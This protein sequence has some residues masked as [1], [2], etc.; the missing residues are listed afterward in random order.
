[1]IP[2][3]LIILIDLGALATAN[4]CMMKQLICPIFVLLS[5]PMFVHSQT[6]M[7]GL[8][9]KPSF[10]YLRSSERANL[11]CNNSENWRCQ[12][13]VPNTYAVNMNYW[14]R[15]ESNSSPFYFQ[16]ELGLMYL[17][18]ELKRFVSN[19][20]EDTASIIIY[21]E[22]SSEK[23]QS[24]YG[25]VLVA[26]GY[27]FQI[28]EVPVQAYLGIFSN[29]PI[30]GR[31]KIYRERTDY[32]DFE[33]TYD[34]SCQ[35]EVYKR[36]PLDG[37]RDTVLNDYGHRSDLNIRFHAGAVAGIAVE[38]PT[39]GQNG[40]SL[41]YRH[42]R[43]L[44]NPNLN[45]FEINS[46]NSLTLS[47]RLGQKT[48]ATPR[49]KADKL[50]RHSGFVLGTQMGFQQY[51]DRYTKNLLSYNFNFGYSTALGI[52]PEIM[53]TNYHQWS[54]KEMSGLSISGGLTFELLN[55]YLVPNIG[56]ILGIYAPWADDQYNKMRGVYIGA[57]LQYP[58]TGRFRI[59]ISSLAHFWFGSSRSPFDP[60]SFDVG[61]FYFFGNKWR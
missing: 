59:R 45:S 50:R 55:G 31:S 9:F 61:A 2:L 39:K 25:Q 52:R 29:L 46:Y 4:Y 18:T 57:G 54:G 30:Y 49:R 56:G 43:V 17:P 37:P 28:G 40:L 27:Q 10:I 58:N 38:L 36:I 41:G 51:D 6:N 32:F 24:I 13:M 44:N 26:G 7:H 15:I 23:Y 47:V 19:T 11:F 33:F 16:G 21:E 14:R 3:T 34:T 22:R 5:L 12:L 8:S 35:C 48:E 53:L 42:E 60:M 20:D 1:M